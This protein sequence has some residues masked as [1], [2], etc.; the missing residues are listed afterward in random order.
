ME[1]LLVKFPTIRPITAYM[2]QVD[3]CQHGKSCTFSI[4]FFTGNLVQV[5]C[6]WCAEELGYTNPSMIHSRLCRDYNCMCVLNK[7]NVYTFLHS[8]FNGALP[9]DIIHYLVPFYIELY[10]CKVC[11]KSSMHIKKCIHCN[12][13]VCGGCIIDY[14]D[15]C[16][17][18]VLCKKCID[19]GHNYFSSLIHGMECHSCFYKVCN[20]CC[21]S[22][23]R[24]GWCLQ[25]MCAT[26]ETHTCQVK[27]DI[28]NKREY[29]WL[30]NFTRFDT[31]FQDA[32]DWYRDT[33]IQYD[34][35]LLYDAIKVE[36]IEDYL[37]QG[38][39]KLDVPKSLRY[40]LR[41]TS[42]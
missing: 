13:N 35:H 18:V 30:Q 14:C 10:K 11:C 36:A 1:E 7:D 16:N 27:Y 29:Y 4:S 15:K 34:V 32:C 39:Y 22:L 17:D 8:A 19:F 20:T 26:T 9:D 24:C 12:T 37:E 38:G 6:N 42:P 40:M 2:Y 21:K 33:K 23:K 25:Y 41:G 31:L 5:S 3:K 28:V